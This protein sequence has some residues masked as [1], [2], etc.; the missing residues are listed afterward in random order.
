MGYVVAGFGLAM[1]KIDTD[2]L[3]W[4]LMAIYLAGIGLQGFR[5]NTEA[6]WRRGFGTFGTIISC[7]D[8]RWSLMRIKAYSAT[9]PGCLQV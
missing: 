8:Y 1:Q 6:P 7:S 5:E 3:A 4:G 2:E 9:S